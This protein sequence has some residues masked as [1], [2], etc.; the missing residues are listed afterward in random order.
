MNDG[1]LR[2]L[3]L[4]ATR[5]GAR[6]KPNV[7]LDSPGGAIYSMETAPNGTIYFSDS[8]GIYKLTR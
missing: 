4:N 7:V 1:K 6:R 5:T 8:G 2:V 3:A